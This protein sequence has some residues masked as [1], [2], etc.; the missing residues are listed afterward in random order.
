MIKKGGHL[1][2]SK[3]AHAE[4]L[5]TLEV[6]S[7]IG[8]C[9]KKPDKVAEIEGLAEA[10][11]KV[12]RKKEDIIANFIRKTPGLRQFMCMYSVFDIEDDRDWFTEVLIEEVLMSEREV[13]ELMT[14]GEIPPDVRKKFAIFKPVPVAYEWEPIRIEY[15]LWGNP[16]LGES[17]DP[18]NI[19]HLGWE[20]DSDTLS[21]KESSDF[22]KQ[23][24][25]LKL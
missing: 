18:I 7:E 6:M 23:Q 9:Q 10:L 5:N 17:T 14:A 16:K 13:R 21:D 24:G 22:I 2:P 8:W 25:V 20:E 1:N 3:W 15:K 12:G 19:I 11:R 4:V